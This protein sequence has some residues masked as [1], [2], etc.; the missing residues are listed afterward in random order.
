MG[1]RWF[2]SPAG[3]GS[4][5]ARRRFVELVGLMVC[6]WTG[7]FI[8]AGLVESSQRRDLPLFPSSRPGK[9]LTRRRVS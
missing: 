2:S 5:V 4:R 9:R 1:Q 3:L 6:S 7:G 8:V